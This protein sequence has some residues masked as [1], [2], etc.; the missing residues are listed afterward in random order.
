MACELPKLCR[1]LFFKPLVPPGVLLLSAAVAAGGAVDDWVGRDPACGNQRAACSIRF[2]GALSYTIQT[3][4]GRSYRLRLT[5][6]E[7]LGFGIRV[8]P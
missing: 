5:F 1:A 8:K 3:V 4:V 6:S 2:G 7:V